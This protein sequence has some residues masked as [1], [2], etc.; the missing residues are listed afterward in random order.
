MVSFYDDIEMNGNSITAVGNLAIDVSLDVIGV[1]L[2]LSSSG[3]V[4]NCIEVKLDDNDYCVVI[5]ASGDTQIFR[6][7]KV[8][9][10][11]IDTADVIVQQSI[12]QSSDLMQFWT[13]ASGI[14]SR[15]NCSGM[16]F[17]PTATHLSGA[18][19]VNQLN[20][21][22]S[23]ISAS[24]GVTV[25]QLNTAISGHTTAADPHTQYLVTAPTALSR[26]VI[27]P[28]SNSY[29]LRINTNFSTMAVSPLLIHD[30]ASII[31][32]LLLTDSYGLNVPRGVVSASGFNANGSF[33]NS[34][35]IATGMAQ[36]PRF[37]QIMSVLSGHTTATDPHTQ[38][39]VTAPTASR[40]TI[41]TP[42]DAYGI[43]IQK[44]FAEMTLGPFEIYD[45][46]T[47]TTVLQIDS[48]Y[49][50]SY[51]GAITADGAITSLGIIT[52]GSFDASL[53]RM[54]NLGA[55]T[56][57]TDAPRFSQVMSV[58]SGHTDG[59]AVHGATG[60]VVG[61]TN[62]QTLTNKTLSAVTLSGAIGDYYEMTFHGID[63]NTVTA[64]ALST[65]GLASA[66]YRHPIARNSRVAFM[67]V[68]AAHAHGSDP[69]DWDVQLFKNGT[70]QATFNVPLSS[71]STSGLIT[72]GKPSSIFNLD[73]GD[74]LHLAAS[75]VS[76]SAILMKVTV[77]F[78]TR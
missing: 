49:L 23:G 52:G 25:E 26:N 65:D 40:N 51:A 16:L 3:R 11:N 72:A 55:A 20:V 59:T 44:S 76:T 10:A 60:A 2:N 33:I 71:S 31:D 75:G 58:L 70:K 35:A 38:Y 4:T 67:A 53:G 63:L 47:D 69:G 30:T 42:L 68:C 61:T 77:G 74:G 34:V 13:T 56:A 27:E 8:F 64:L 28:D 37:S 5:N 62:T 36:A 43:Y 14:I 66:Q 21:A 78:E 15:F 19:N 18:V 57:M 9:G 22:I 41:S 39:L 48:D 29:G 46:D 12:G 32:V 50:L 1:E 17:V 7:L 54:V 45:N 73:A 6:R 24:A